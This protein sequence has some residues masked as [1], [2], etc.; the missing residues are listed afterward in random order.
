MGKE[1]SGED[2]EATGERDLVAGE[3]MEEIGRKTD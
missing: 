2:G 1:G 3:G